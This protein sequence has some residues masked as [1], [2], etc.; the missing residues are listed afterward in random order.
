V[1]IRA[2]SVAL[3]TLASA[4]SSSDDRAA[5]GGLDFEFAGCARIRPGPLCELGADR[6]LTLW[7]Q[8]PVKP[9]IEAAGAVRESTSDA[10]FVE[11]GWRMKFRV[12]QTA[13]E[14][15]VRAGALRSTLRVAGSSEPRP[16]EELARL[17][18]AGQWEQVRASLDATAA[19]LQGAERERI[20]A[21]R[22]RQAM[23]DGDDARAAA[24]L[25]QSAV[26]AQEAGLLLE[27][28]HDRIAAA[29]CRAVRLADYGRARAE[30]EAT[31]REL[32]HIP[33]V[34]A[35]LAYHRGVLAKTTGDTQSALVHF[36]DA[37]VLSRRLDLV[38]DE[39]V[40]HQE[41]ALTL[42][43]LQRHSEAL[44]EQEA[45][46]ARDV[47]G[48]SCL[49]SLRWENLAW[50]LLSQPDPSLQQRAA[51]ALDRAERLSERC[52]DPLARRNQ[53][54]NR[55]ELALRRGDAADA[56][57][58]LQ[59]LEADSSGRSTRLAAWQALYSGRVHLLRSDGSSG[60]LAAF[61]Q[62]AQLA[63]SI[64]LKDCAYLAKL[65]RARALSLRSDAGAIA[66]YF[67][68][69]DAADALVR[70]AP[71]G[72]GQQLTALQ[73][74]EGSRELLSLLLARNQIADAYAL[75]VRT[76]RR[77][78][79]SNFRASRIAALSGVP[80]ERWERAVSEYSTRRR[81]LE[82]AARDDWKLSA[83]GFAET[84][85]SRAL[86]LQRLENALA[87]AYALLS[88]DADHAPPE[89]DDPQLTLASGKYS[90]W[91]FLARGDALE[92]SL[93]AASSDRDDVERG[94]VVALESFEAAGLMGAE[95]LRV[96]LP[97]EHA[98][99]DV[100][101]LEIGGRPLAERLPVA[102]SFDPGQSSELRAADDRPWSML[103]LG[104]PNDDLP[105]AG[106]EARRLSK[107]FSASL[108]LF[109][110][111]VTFDA[112]N[113][114]LPNAT[115]LHFAGHA[116]SGGLDG[117]DGA[118]RLRAGERLSLGDVFS[119]RRVP[120]FVVLSACT[121]SVSPGAGGGLSIGQAFVA[122][123]SRA[124]IGAS[125]PVS[126]ALA[127][128]FTQALYDELFGSDTRA[129]L[130]RDSRAWARA[131]RAASMKVKREDPAADWASMRLLLP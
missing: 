87:E 23:R 56:E 64:E 119:L 10:R 80:R 18:K 106:S 105:S 73:T 63:E 120:E 39:L 60:A 129:T 121:S 74:Q 89:T 62:A 125:R 12:P 71:F 4:L 53:A 69:E 110:E 15:R 116:N 33:E 52:P 46:V 24:E 3:L 77:V 37:S 8:G 131:T 84:R 95:M 31:E 61:E 35:R 41:L 43:R 1:A 34:R 127:Q 93:V 68:A 81:A 49:Y 111:E 7:I 54:L 48:P 92:V 25:E 30:L 17:W 97:P 5:V 51:T 58:R 32:G 79:A 55:V 101:A 21:F 85:L 70:W 65:G 124:V 26:S 28:S 103:V 47:D 20:R 27:A 66:A 38:S 9:Q 40:A 113:A 13:R 42:N 86:A 44:A 36:R 130:P 83:E 114:R 6:E 100:H 128:R 104:D 94:L 82:R 112:V 99:L 50:I 102:Y 19:Q 91:A 109:G 108:A 72:Q 123:G 88:G 118:L 126:D 45:V 75:A 22:A 107:R 57:L 122:A 16:L 76:T 14:V 96:T 11:S 29:Y 67:Q 98:A 90:W 115:L 78:W 2:L 117:L 59:A